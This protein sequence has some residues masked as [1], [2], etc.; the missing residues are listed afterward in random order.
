MRRRERDAVIGPNPLGKSKLFEGALE[1][2]EGELLL[3]GAEGLAREQVT[4]GEVRDG[5]RIAVLA[6]A[7]QKLAFIVGTPERIRVGGSRELG[8]R[9]A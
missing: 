3:R 6:I 1:N 5:Q 8:P 9:G 7:E 4:T 2:R